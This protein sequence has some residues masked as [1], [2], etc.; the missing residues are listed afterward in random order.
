MTKSKWNVEWRTGR[1]NTR[2]LRNMSQ[3]LDT[4]AGLKLYGA[5][6]QRK[7]VV[8]ITWLHTG[9]CHLNE[10][11]H[12][13]NI[14]ETAKCECKILVAGQPFLGILWRE[15]RYTCIQFLKTTELRELTGLYILS[16]M[17]TNSYWRCQHPD[18]QK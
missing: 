5:L 4:T 1:E 3:Y 10:Y 6:Q 15:F 14:I 16:D 17:T 13:F 11:L 18:G 12:R 9:H 8:C 7:Y 2:C